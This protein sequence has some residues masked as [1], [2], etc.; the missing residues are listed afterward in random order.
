MQP[1]DQLQL[2]GTFDLQ[3]EI[4]A[5]IARVEASIR[6]RIADTLATQRYGHLNKRSAGQIRRRMRENDARGK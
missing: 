4:T 3:A 5:A 6:R 1:S 2:P